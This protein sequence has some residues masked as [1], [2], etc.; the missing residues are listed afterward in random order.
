MKK[1]GFLFAIGLIIFNFSADAQI[2]N[3]MDTNIKVSDSVRNKI[4]S[5][6]S[7]IAD[8]SGL[9]PNERINPSFGSVKAKFNISRFPEWMF[10]RV[11]YTPSIPRKGE[12]SL[13]YLLAVVAVSDDKNFFMSCN[14]N[15]VDFG[16]FLK[17]NHFK[18]ENSNDLAS[19][20]QLLNKILGKNRRGY[21]KEINGHYFQYILKLPPMSHR[22][23]PKMMPVFALII[24]TNPQYEVEYFKVDQIAPK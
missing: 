2:K 7:S 13:P 12:V 22:I 6:I 5:A 4:E 8:D 24:K 3:L 19:T 18:I 21:I 10:Y 14:G 17:Y 16:N 9:K 20:I 15:Y 1:I 23:P 11:S